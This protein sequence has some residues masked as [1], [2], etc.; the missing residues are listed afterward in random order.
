HKRASI[1]FNAMGLWEFP[2]NYYEGDMGYRQHDNAIYCR[3]EDILDNFMSNTSPN[4]ND[5]GSTLPTFIKNNKEFL[6]HG[7]L[8]PMTS[9]FIYIKK[10][11][12]HDDEVAFGTVYVPN[13]ELFG[14]EW[15]SSGEEEYKNNYSEAYKI[16]EKYLG[17][18]LDQEESYYN[19]V[20]K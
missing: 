6:I 11:E 13:D 20:R 3:H 1:Y 9:T 18:H 14:R 16:F 12:R 10:F 8:F 5:Y 15:R 2:K 7:I 17:G 19:K 4:P